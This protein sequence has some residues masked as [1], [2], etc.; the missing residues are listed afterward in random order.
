MRL[1]IAARGLA[2]ISAAAA[3]PGISGSIR[4]THDGR[5]GDLQGKSVALEPATGFSFDTPMV[6]KPH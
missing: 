4:V 1:S 3:A 5:F 2:V 6:F